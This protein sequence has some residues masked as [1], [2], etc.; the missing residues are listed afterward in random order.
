MTV[1]IYFQIGGGRLSATIHSPHRIGIALSGGFLKAA[2]HVG[3]LA[4]LEEL[5]IHPHRIAGTS[6]GAFVAT[7][8]AHGYSTNDLLDLIRHFPGA[9]LFDYGFPVLSSL[10][11]LWWYK[12][13][14][15]W[16][17]A[18]LRLPRGLIRGKKLEKYFRKRLRLRTAVMPYYVIAT[19]LL[20]GEPVVYSNDESSIQEGFA[21]PVT[22]VS[23]AVLGSCSIPG[24]LSPV[25]V[26][27]RLL[28][29]GAFRHYVPVEVL[30]QAGCNKIIAVNL[31]RLQEEWQPE[32]F[33]HVLARSFEILLQE[34]IE[35][36]VDGPDI[37]LL[38]PNVGNLSWVSFHKMEACVEDGRKSVSE[39]RGEIEQ[40]LRPPIQW[41]AK[42]RV[43]QPGL[44]IKIS[45]HNRTHNKDGPPLEDR[46]HG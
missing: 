32:T 42:Q 19:D 21:V 37:V 20:S 13:P 29:D 40:L 38:E 11:N 24:V 10:V 27:G 16:R 3:V 1:R 39:K 17:G 41:S 30:R 45:Y 31:Y 9:S 43:A 5:G 12:Y 23:Q 18:T 46:P 4:G 7:M 26:D 25:F 28:V 34:S 2:A 22:D 44:E 8:Y 35:D 36:D 15:K 6:A 14:V 33:V